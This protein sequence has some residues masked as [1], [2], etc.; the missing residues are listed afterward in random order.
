VDFYKGYGCV[1]LAG[2]AWLAIV[3]LVF[4]VS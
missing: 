4:L 3:A 1:A 2:L